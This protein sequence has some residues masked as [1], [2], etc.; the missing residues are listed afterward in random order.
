MRKALNIEKKDFHEV[1]INLI[2]KK[3]QMIAKIVMARALNNWMTK[4][5][6][7]EIG[8]MFVFICDNIGIGD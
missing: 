7:E 1:I 4:E 6:V 5:K 8:Q 3:R 2:K